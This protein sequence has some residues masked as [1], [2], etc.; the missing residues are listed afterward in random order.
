MKIIGITGKSG[1]AKTSFESLLVK[2]L[3]CTYIDIDK[4]GNKETYEQKIS[5]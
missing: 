5:K 3:N 2:T 1:I 4:I